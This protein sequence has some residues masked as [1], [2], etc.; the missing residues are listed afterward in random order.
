MIAQAYCKLKA[1]LEVSR[2]LR[3]HWESELNTA[4]ALTVDVALFDKSLN[5]EGL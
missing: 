4:S 1:R 3:N 5:L 2:N